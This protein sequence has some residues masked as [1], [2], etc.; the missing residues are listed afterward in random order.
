MSIL[1]YSFAL[2]FCLLASAHAG[3]PTKRDILV[4]FR[5]GANQ[6]EI[7]KTYELTVTKVM[8]QDP[9]QVIVTALSH[10]KA[11]KAISQLVRNPGVRNADWAPT[12]PKP[13]KPAAT[14][15]PR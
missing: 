8:P 7:A 12:T 14:A 5:P 4:T 6:A 13:R 1:R 15:P 9:N 3:T 2:L 11:N 10:D